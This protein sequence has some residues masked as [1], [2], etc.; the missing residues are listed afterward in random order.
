MNLKQPLPVPN[1]GPNA[2]CAEDDALAS[3]PILTADAEFRVNAA[4]EAALFAFARAVNA[5]AD[6]LESFTELNC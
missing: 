5:A 3:T 1:A 6:V 4:T 2:A